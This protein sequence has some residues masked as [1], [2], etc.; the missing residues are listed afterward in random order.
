LVR[1]ALALIAPAL[2]PVSSAAASGQ[3]TGTVTAGP[4]SSA[5][6]VPGTQVY[7][8][9]PGTNS[10]QATIAT[11]DATGLYSL[12]VPAGAYD[13]EFVPPALGTTLAAQ[14]WNGV[15]V[16]PLTAAPSVSAPAAG[17]TGV[18]VT[19]GAVTPNVSAA[20][21]LLG[22][23]KGTVTDTAGRPLRGIA[24]DVESTAGLLAHRTSTAA[25][26]SYTV[27]GL[28]PGGY[29]VQFSSAMGHYAAQ[30]S[31][32]LTVPDGGVITGVNARLS[33]QTVGLLIGRRVVAR[34][35]VVSYRLV[36]GETPA[37][38]GSVVL[39]VR[40]HGRDVSAASADVTAP[41]NTTVRRTLRLSAPVRAALRRGPLSATLLLGT[42]AASAS[43][44]FT[45]RG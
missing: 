40:L 17:V 14:W 12:S 27:L 22:V 8:F 41:A 20:L 4:A 29:R 13:V 34:S 25:D 45:L 44:R 31:G 38:S 35:G 23:V 11:T 37:C 16:D 33:P 18:T 32:A 2:V 28:L 39:R 21:P 3:I 24:V 30:S 7:A 26:G 5:T 42:D 1:V 43:R 10:F 36:C 19:D 6:P 15:D 9:T